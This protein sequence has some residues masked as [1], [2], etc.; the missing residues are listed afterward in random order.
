MKLKALHRGYVLVALMTVTACDR[1]DEDIATDKAS[2]ADEAAADGKADLIDICAGWDWYDDDFCDDPYGWCAQPDPDCGPDGDSCAEGWTWS[3]VA[4]EGCVEAAPEP[5]T[6]GE[7]IVIGQRPGSASMQAAWVSVAVDTNDNPHVVY[8]DYAHR[9][10]Y[11][12]PV[13]A[14]EA[15]VLDPTLRVDRGLTM[16]ADAQVH[17]AV[18]DHEYDLHYLHLDGASIADRDVVHTHSRSV[19]MALSP[20]E[21]HLVF[22]AGETSTSLAAA[23]GSLGEMVVEGVANVANAVEARDAP[24]IATAPDGSLHVLYGVARPAYH[25]GNFSPVRY[26][27]RDSNGS[28]HDQ[29]VSEDSMEAGA[30]T[31]QA[32]GVLFAAFRGWVDGYQTLMVAENDGS[33]WQTEALLGNAVAGTAVNAT[34]APDGALHIVFRRDGEVQHVERPLGADW[35]EPVTLD[36]SAVISSSDRIGLAIGSDGSVHVAY[37]DIQ[38]RDVRYVSRP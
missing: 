34:T 13:D 22:G 27:R 26:A 2:I 35:T 1:S 21:T 9:V 36:P 10:T 11:A 3:G 4:S 12:S 17:V 6:F 20:G 24:S 28:W 16:S 29:A 32:D 18:I 15:H 31:V 23:N 7:P 30:L 5:A 25:F 33:G 37:G 8:P 38:T 19:G 14:W